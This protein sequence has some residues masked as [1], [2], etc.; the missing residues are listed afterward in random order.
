[1]SSFLEFLFALIISKSQSC[2]ADAV[3]DDVLFL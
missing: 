3:L 2:L 1:M